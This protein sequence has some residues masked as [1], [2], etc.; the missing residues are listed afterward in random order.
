MSE[1]FEKYFILSAFITSFFGVFITNG[2]IIGTPEIA[3]DF[4]MNNV[5]QNWIPTI[6]VLVVTMF[7]VPFGQICGKYGFKKAWVIA[8]IIKIIGLVI[9]CLS[10]STE[11]FFTSR[12]LQG[13][14]IAMGNVCEM[15]IVVLAIDNE[16]RG[17]ALGIIVTGVYL[18]TSLSPVACGFLVQDF[19]WRSM[20]YM[21][22]IF[23]SIATAILLL[24]THGE[25]KTNENDSLDYKGMIM[26]ALGIFFLI[27]GISIFMTLEGQ[28]MAVA[29]ILI[30]IAFGYYELHQKSPVFYVKLLK[31]HSFTLYNIAGMFGYMA[32]MM[33][34]TIFNYHFQYVK[35][36][37]PEMT[38][39][40]LL[41][42]PVVMSIVAPNAGKLSDKIHPQKIAAIGMFITIFAFLILIVMDANTPLPLIIL[43][44]VLQAVGMGLFSSP[45][46]NAVMSSVDEKYAAHASASQITVRGIGQT[47]SLTIV[48]LVFGWVM[49]TLVLSSQ[50]SDM[51]VESSQI[52]C[53]ICAVACVIAVITSVI[54][55]RLDKNT[56][57]SL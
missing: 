40:I 46:M 44:M 4:G 31:K 6:L 11:M 55:I 7:T 16:K 20:F 33:I 47:L 52:I 23:N 21:T 38:G 25:W 3:A 43:A 30:I 5:L 17:R 56:D 24:K 42:S 32:V 1:N 53:L 36:W 34:T 8:Q 2:V 29:G 13:I 51:I 37:N 39:I 45:N 57:S 28:A 12:V 48:T 15:A 10:I 14:G 54:G 22:I 19:G 18:G 26:Y 41:V 50:Y 35:G 49:G 9:C 27:Y